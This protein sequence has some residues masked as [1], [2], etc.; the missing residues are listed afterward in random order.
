LW[1]LDFRFGIWDLD[2]RFGFEISNPKSE[3]QI[4]ISQLESKSEISNPNLQSRSGFEISANCHY[5]YF[6]RRFPLRSESVYFISTSHRVHNT[7]MYLCSVMICLEVTCKLWYLFQP[8]DFI[9]SL[10]IILLPEYGLGLISKSTCYIM[11][12]RIGASSMCLD[13]KDAYYSQS[14]MIQN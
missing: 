1:D 6:P 9:A 5:Y 13:L 14:I 4:K 10:V 8:H 3:S 12:A 7:H 2:L 11:M